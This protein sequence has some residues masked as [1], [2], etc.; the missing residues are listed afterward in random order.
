MKSVYFDNAATTPLREEVINS[1]IESLNKSFG[2]PSS[3][4]VYGREAKAILEQCRKEIAQL[5]KAQPSEII[6]TSGG[7]EADNFA[8]KSAVEN[9]GVTTIITSKVEHHAVLHCVEALQEKHNIAVKFVNVTERGEISLEHLEQLLA[10][11]STQN[12]L[13]SLMHINNEIGTILPLLRVAQLCKNNN[14]L[15]HSDMVQSFGHYE[16]DFS[17]NQVDFA[18][19]A[20]HKFHG[21]KGIGFAFVRKNSALKPIIYGGGQERG[22]RAGTEA[23]H[24]VLGMTQALKIAYE[25]LTE[26]QKYVENLKA[27]FIQTVK[28]EIPQV[29]FNGLCDDFNKSTYTLVNLNLPISKE[30]A[31][32]LVF[33]LDLKGIACSQ[34]SACQS[35]STNGSHV[36][37]AFLTEDKLNNPSLRFSFSVFN[38]IEEVDYLVSVL[39][40]FIDS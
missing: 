34:G 4:H 36:L 7:T 38:T 1:M 16:I 8:L 21:P 24:N 3:T 6:F 25:N 19:A 39:K 10:H 26:E 29:T 14:A 12:V 18:A 32:L 17:A 13:V 37:Q 31:Q 9:L 30:K 11:Y 40:E 20:A 33:Q 23:V 22:L 27:Y 35:G 2:N 5:V 28:K 15:F